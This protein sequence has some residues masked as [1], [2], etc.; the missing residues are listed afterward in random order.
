MRDRQNPMS[1]LCHLFCVCRSGKS[2]K[3][4]RR[5]TGETGRHL[6][7]CPLCGGQ[8]VYVRAHLKHAHRLSE[9]DVDSAMVGV[10]RVARN[11]P[12]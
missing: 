11:T 8:K 5:N 10:P 12:K 1:K 4:A 6:H 7:T 3:T 9:A 2:R